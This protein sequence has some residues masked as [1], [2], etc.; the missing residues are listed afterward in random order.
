MAVG[1]EQPS[2]SDDDRLHLHYA[3]GKALE[4]AAL[5]RVLRALRQGRGDA[6]GAG[7]LRSRGKPRRCGALEGG[8]HP[9]SSGGHG[10]GQG[11]PAPDPIFV[12]GLPRSGSTLVEQILASHSAGRGHHGAARPDR[13]GPRLGGKAN[14]REDST[15]PEML[16]DLTPEA[17]A[18]AWR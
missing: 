16:A 14:R 1:L 17:S 9:G 11:C 4:D 12:L 8:V 6:A 3:L 7:R 15:Y 2:L 10:A 13:H 5:R 18:C